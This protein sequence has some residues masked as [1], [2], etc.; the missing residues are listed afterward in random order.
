MHAIPAA[1]QLPAA[2][3][4]G[5]LLDA[6]GKVIS[7]AQVELRDQ[8]SGRSYTENTNEHGGFTFPELVPGTYD[9]MVHWNGNIGTPPGRESSNRVNT[10]T[11]PFR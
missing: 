4:V 2:S 11:C 10:L 9:V 1:G 7:G 5:T 6:E 3:W 8:A